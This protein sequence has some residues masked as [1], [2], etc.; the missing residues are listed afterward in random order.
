[1]AM[2]MCSLATGCP[3]W[4]P[5]SP[6]YR[7]AGTVD[8]VRRNLTGAKYTLA[9]N[10]AGAALGIT[11]FASIAA[12]AEALDGKIY[13]IE[14]G[15]DGNRLILDMIEADAFGLSGF[16]A[17][18]PE[19]TIARATCCF[20]PGRVAARG[21]PGRGTIRRLVLFSLGRRWEPQPSLKKRGNTH[22]DMTTN[23]GPVGTS[24]TGIGHQIF[25]R[26]ARGY[27]TEPTYTRAGFAG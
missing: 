15:N 8:T 4:K 23:T 26:M 1:M 22:S 20:R 9:T 25:E 6:P 17:G 14:P 7:E 12:Q 2:S 27:I 3:R 21:R 11:D 18:S 16:E 19:F 5:I 10:A 24:D 13:G